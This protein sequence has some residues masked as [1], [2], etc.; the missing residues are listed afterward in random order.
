MDTKE[1]NKIAVF[2]WT[3][4]PPVVVFFGTVGNIL[5]IIAAFGNKINSF[6]VYLG[7]LAIA[8]LLVLYTQTLILWL[9]NVF[10]ISFKDI[11]L[12]TCKFY[13]FFIFLTP[14]L[15]SWFVMCLT[16]ERTICMFFITKVRQFPS[17]KVGLTVVCII[18]G[19][20]C[21]LNGHALY[22]REFAAPPNTSVSSCGFISEAYR[23]FYYGYWNIINFI[24]YFVLP[25]IVIIIGNSISSYKVYKSA[26]SFTILS[27]SSALRQKMR[28]VFVLTLLV[29][30][31]FIVLVTPLPLLFLFTPVNTLQFP[32]AAFVHMVSLNHSI[33]FFLYILSGSRFRE[34][35]KL[36]LGRLG[37]LS[38]RST[39]SVSGSGERG[40]EL[41]EGTSPLPT[42]SSILESPTSKT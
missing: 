10:E 5:T 33:N 15:S 20:L 4:V 13:Y 29:S 28:H 38:C 1:L 36:S 39:T 7:S 8:D 40:F 24:T 37:V 14:Q 31:A 35:L 27:L 11:S 34:D 41:P 25:I 21:A 3:Y 9:Q 22:G 18:V 2:S 32:A 19:L 30:I 16:I 17:P 23:E 42:R 26:R 6:S 12:L